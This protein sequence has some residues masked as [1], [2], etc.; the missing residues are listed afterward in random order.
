MRRRLVVAACLVAVVACKKDEPASSSS[1]TEQSP[2]AKK[3]AKCDAFAEQMTKTAAMAGKMLVAA[4]D[5]DGK[6]LSESEQKEVDVEADELRKDLAEK[7]LDWPEETME[8]LSPMAM[9]REG[10]EE[11]ILAAIEGATAMPSEIAAGPKVEWSFTFE[12]QPRHL[13]V[14]DDGTV[15]ALAGVESNEII[16]LRDGTVAWRKEGDFDPWLVPLGEGVF[17]AAERDELVAFS[18][19]DGARRWSASLPPLPEDEGGSVPDIKVAAKTMG[20]R[21]LVGDGEARFFTVEPKGCEKPGSI[22][23][24]VSTAGRLDDEMLDGDARLYVDADDR[25]YLWEDTTVRIFDGRWTRQATIRAH[26][27]LDQVRLDGDRLALVTDGDVVEL[28]PSKCQAEARFAVSGW[29]Q[30]GALVY[31][32]ADECSDCGSPPAGCRRWRA[33]VEDVSSEVFARL[34]DGTLVVHNDEITRAFDDE[35]KQ[36][37]AL[38]ANFGGPLVGKGDRVFGFSTGTG[39]TAS[40]SILELDGKTGLPRWK[41]SLALEIGEM[42]YSD[43]IQL[44]LSPSMLA[45]GYEQTVMALKLPAAG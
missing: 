38:A 13:A 45:V 26:D 9:M 36:R 22:I 24:C 19:T 12:S 41:T 5:E 32:D 16:A 14:A 6:G 3:K 2:A 4:L 43:D 18:A 17:V 10:C 39:E 30:P 21:L 11:R 35:G 27:D 15:L 1:T 8:C 33:Y 42:Y 7:C 29:P 31:R 37:W 23:T 40:V 44:A 34:G 28:I 25:R 20:S